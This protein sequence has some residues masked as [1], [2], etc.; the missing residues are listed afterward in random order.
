MPPSAHLFLPNWFTSDLPGFHTHSRTHYCEP[1]GK[2]LIKV[3]QYSSHTRRRHVLP[4]GRRCPWSTACSLSQEQLAGRLGSKDW[5][6]D[7]RVFGFILTHPCK[8]HSSLHWLKMVSSFLTVL[9]DVPNIHSLLKQE[10]FVWCEALTT[11]EQ[12]LREQC[13]MYICSTMY[14][15]LNIEL[16]N[17][18]KYYFS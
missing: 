14:F 17:I 15:E 3:M 11:E 2:N 9:Q 5:A 4:E 7:R 8:T 10:L 12:G 16:F 13:F 18:S 1:P 6:T